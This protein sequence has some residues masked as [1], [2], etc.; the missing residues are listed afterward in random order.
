MRLYIFSLL[1]LSNFTF[2]QHK[3]INFLKSK[4]E[5][6]YIGTLAKNIIKSNKV[7][8][9]TF[10]LSNKGKVIFSKSYGYADTLKK[11]PLNLNHR[12]FMN[13]STRLFTATGIL[14]LIQENKIT[15][16]DN[17]FGPNSILASVIP[18]AAPYIDQTK[19]K[20]LLEKTVSLPSSFRNSDKLLN[21]KSMTNRNLSGYSP[22]ISTA[23]N[24]E[25][26][27]V[28]G[29][30]LEHLHEKPYPQIISEMTKDIFLNKVSV[31]DRKDFSDMA[32]FRNKD[33]LYDRILSFDA[34][35]G[36]I[37]SPPDMMNFILSIDGQPAVPDI[38][39]PATHRIFKSP[40]P[41]IVKKGKA[42]DIDNDG[43]YIAS[44]NSVSYTYVRSTKEGISW[45]ICINGSG[46]KKLATDV[47]SFPK[48]VI[49]RI[50][51]LP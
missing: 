32:I 22:G 16:E 48:K 29:Y 44:G 51:N 40:N 4:A 49:R 24:Y 7:H 1:I 11:I 46:T 6:N 42:W 5:Y 25:C 34:L 41:T 17:V 23:Y 2:G 38:I 50:K 27:Y 36:I 14:Q 33:D 28:L 20:H 3:E 13:D 8:G 43:F 21:I 19:L 47:F 26:Y 39:I 30:I 18:K 45:V 12:M 31:H 37:C 35:S 10:L 9:L 15:L